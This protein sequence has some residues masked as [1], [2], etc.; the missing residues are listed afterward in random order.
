MKNPFR[1]GQLVK[2]EDFCNRQEELK[3]IKNAISNNYSFWIYSPRRFGKTSLIQRAFEELPET[4]TLYIDLY[5]IESLDSFAEKY[6]QL[7]IKELFNWK[8]GIKNIGKKLSGFFKRMTPKVSFDMQGNP[9]ISFEPGQVEDKTD[10]D[11]ILE[12]PEKIVSQQ[13][14]HVCIAFDEFQEAQRI[15]PFLIN[16]MRSAFQRHQHIS[17]IFLGSKQSLMETIFADPNSPFYEFGVKIPIKEIQRQDWQTFIKGKFDK[18]GI[19]IT[20]AT[21][22]TIIDKSGGH[23][24]FTQYFASVVWEFI[25][26]GF[27]PNDRSFTDNWM[28]RIIAGQSILFQNLYDQLNQNQR[29][30]LKT[31]ACLESGQQIFSAKIRK[32]Y[33]LPSSSTLTVTL[34]TL[35]KKDLIGKSNG[36]YTILNPVLKEWLFQQ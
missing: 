26:E 29:K 14:G 20:N 34:N 22:D 9:S 2:G 28:S 36:D 7:V 24:H 16:W 3:E 30:T 10:I 18:T 17:Y 11:N 6:A 4:K 31:I 1:F 27:D 33:R 15:D 25:V 13:S 8:S 19:P 23:P 35:I 32:Q 12:I 5:N 21:I